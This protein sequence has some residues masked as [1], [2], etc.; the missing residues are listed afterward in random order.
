MLHAGQDMLQSKR[1][2]GNT[3]Q[4]G[5]INTLDYG[6]LVKNYNTHKFFEQWIKFRLSRHGIVL[7]PPFTPS[8]TYIRFFQSPSTSALGALYNADFSM[9]SKRIFFA[10]NPH[11]K[12]AQST[13]KTSIWAHFANCPTKTNFFT[14]PRN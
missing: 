5:G 2:M 8:G 4:L 6:L 10:I 1:G 11:V 12:A 3:Y 14:F 9:P 7:R 13:L